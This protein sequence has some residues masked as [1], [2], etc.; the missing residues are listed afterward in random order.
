MHIA[1]TE[2]DVKIFPMD[3][4]RICVVINKPRMAEGERTDA[5]VTW[6]RRTE[7][8]ASQAYL[9]AQAIFIGAGLADIFNLSV[10]LEVIKRFGVKY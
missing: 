2:H 8:H 4:D 10:N 1:Y 6:P 3:D 7:A 5:K 9:L